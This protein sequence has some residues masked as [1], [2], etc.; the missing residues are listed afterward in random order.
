MGPLGDIVRYIVEPLTGQKVL[1]MLQ[2]F[3]QHAW[4]GRTGKQI[5]ANS[6][7]V[8]EEHY[9]GIRAKTPKER[10]LEFKLSDGWGPLC[11][12]LGKD[13]PDVEFPR[14][15]DAADFQRKV[16]ETIRLYVLKAAK[17]VLWPVL[18]AVGAA[19][20]WLS[21]RTKGK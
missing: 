2:L 18:L 4:R 19:A 9:A 20:A 6:R 11:Q 12:F 21:F 7:A 14:I 8:Y 10:L 1:Y 5:L 16:D 15:N 13:V 3:Y 17:V